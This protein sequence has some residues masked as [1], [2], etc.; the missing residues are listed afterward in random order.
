MELC[1]RWRGRVGAVGLIGTALASYPGFE[2]LCENI[3]KMGFA[4][5][6]SSLRIEDLT[7]EK[8][9]FIAGLGIK[10]ITLAPES[11]S[12]IL[13]RQIGKCF[14]NIEMNGLFHSLGNLPF[15]K[16]KLY[17]MY[18]IPGESRDDLALMIRSI[19]EARKIMRNKRVDVSIN[20]LIPKAWTP[21]QWNPLPSREE[22]EAKRKY[23]ITSCRKSL[24]FTPTLYSAAGIIYQTAL[25]LGGSALGK[26]L[27]IDAG[28]KGKI[29]QHWK[30]SGLKIDE[31]VHKEKTRN[32]V[33]PWDFVDTGIRKDKLYREYA[34]AKGSGID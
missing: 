33:F 2:A 18:G 4:V 34:R 28:S 7:E 8:L 16:V 9:K 12:D 24:K 29:L 26:G 17:Y 27:Q 25:S 19:A 20:C 23:I 5:R 31:L 11:A 1:D 6:L 30:S 32:F 22:I 10:T 21:F 13:R 15:K 3:K 14:S